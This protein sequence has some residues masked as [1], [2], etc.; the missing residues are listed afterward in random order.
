M[1]HKKNKRTRVSQVQLFETF[2]FHQRQETLAKQYTWHGTYVRR[3]DAVGLGASVVVGFGASLVVGLDSDA[4]AV[5][6]A[7]TLVQSLMR[8]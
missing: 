8:S 6:D 4:C 1:K 5:V 7:Q 3:A 2:S